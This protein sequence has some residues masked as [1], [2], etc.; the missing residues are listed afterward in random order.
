[1]KPCPKP[2]R[3]VNEKLI[4]EVR[5]R[6]CMINKDCYGGLDVHHI[7]SRGS[8]GGDTL[9]NTCCLCRKHHQLAHMGKISKKTLYELLENII[10]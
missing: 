5:N 7:K 8:G 6:G 10:E 1:M 2:K 3:E 9:E 4:V